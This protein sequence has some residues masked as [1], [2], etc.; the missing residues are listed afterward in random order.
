M[1]PNKF[2]DAAAL[3]RW[4][5]NFH[6]GIFDEWECSGAVELEIDFWDWLKREHP[7]MMDDFEDYFLREV[8]V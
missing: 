8:K 7:D 1:R 6:F 2:H 5:N 4:A 3:E